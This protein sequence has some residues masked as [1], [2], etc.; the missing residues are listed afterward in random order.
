MSWVKD[1]SNI[2]SHGSLPGKRNIYVSLQQWKFNASVV[3]RRVGGRAIQ[4][5]KPITG[6][7]QQH[8]C[9]HCCCVLC[10]VSGKLCCLQ[11]LA[12]TLNICIRALPFFWS[13]FPKFANTDPLRT[14]STSSLRSVQPLFEESSWSCQLESTFCVTVS[15]WEMVCCCRRSTLKQTD[16]ELQAEWPLFL[17]RYCLSCL[18]CLGLVSRIQALLDQECM[19]DISF[20]SLLPIPFKT[21]LALS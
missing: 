3:P 12:W 2:I 6:K 21:S 7:Y 11:V 5:F 15:N 1:G 14:R 8:N 13:R 18:W 16:L 19:E 10:W 17:S 20:A 9:R 4:G